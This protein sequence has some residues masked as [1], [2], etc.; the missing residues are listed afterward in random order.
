MYTYINSR[1][2]NFSQHGFN[3]LEKFA[4]PCKFIGISFTTD[5]HRKYNQDAH[6]LQEFFSCQ[7]TTLNFIQQKLI[8]NTCS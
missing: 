3:I 4:P 7:K 5:T 1:K 8:E 2:R 6:V